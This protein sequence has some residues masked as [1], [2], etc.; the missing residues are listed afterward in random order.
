MLHFVRLTNEAAWEKAQRDKEAFLCAERNFARDLGTTV[1]FIGEESLFMDQL[2]EQIIETAQRDDPMQLEQVAGKRYFYWEK[3]R[4][5]GLSHV[6]TSVDSNLK[7][8]GREEEAALLADWQAAIDVIGRPHRQ[9]FFMRQVHSNMVL[10]VDHHRAKRNVSSPTVAAEEASELPGAPYLLGRRIDLPGGP[11]GL[12]SDDPE[13]LLSSSFGDCVPLLFYDPR[14]NAQAN[15]HSGWRGTLADI[16]GSAMAC[17]QTRYGAEAADLWLAIG[18]HIERDDFEVSED[19][20]ELF[21]AKWGFIPGAVRPAVGVPGKY[22]VDLTLIL[23]YQALSRGIRPER[24]LLCR[25][26][27]VAHPQDYHSYRRDKAEF[28]LMMLLSQLPWPVQS[29]SIPGAPGSGRGCA[30]CPARRKPTDGRRPADGNSRG[31][32]GGPV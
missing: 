22:L 5:M 16:A 8:G 24:L 28:G 10:S 7:I 13:I 17:L 3:L 27:T 12:A 14:R 20:A 9:Y 2:M 1:F 31:G 30:P 29:A 23:L 6:Y 11:D 25:R 19:V 26:S 4:A 21:R 15:V 18:P 32:S